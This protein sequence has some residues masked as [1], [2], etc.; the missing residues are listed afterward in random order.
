VAEPEEER[1]TS[2]VKLAVGYAVARILADSPTLAAATP[3][4]LEQIGEA[5]GWE[6]GALWE[7]E[8][9]TEMLRCVDTWQAAGLD[10]HGF[11]ERSKT[12]SFTPG[13]GL[14][15]RVWAAGEPAWI[16]D[17]TQDE[18]FPLASAAAEAG[19]HGAL[20]FPV[21]GATGILGVME[22]FSREVKAP[23]ERLLEAMAAAGNQIG[24]FLQSRLGAE[25]IRRS[26][27]LKTAMLASA[28]DCVIAIDHEGRIIEFN[29]A[30]ER[31]FGYK[32]EDVIGEEMAEL[33]IPPHLRERHRHGLARYLAGG[34][35]PVLDKPVE[36]PAMRSDG[37][38]F[39]AEL[40]ITRIGTDD[41]PMFSGYV[42][43]IT[44][45]K[46]HQQAREF[47]MRA[48]AA[49]DE[50]LDLDAM[51]QTIARLT[52]PYLADACMVDLLE[53]DGSIRRAAS[54][55]GDPSFEPVLEDLRRHRIDPHGAHPVAKAIRTG[56]IELVP[57]ISDSFFWA[58]AG[59][60][61]H[62]NALSRLPAQAALV[63]PLK[64][65]GNM[66]GA[67]LL[68]SFSSER[69]YGPHEMIVIEELSS[70]AAS[71]IENARLFEERSQ[72][73][74]TL[75]QSLL[76]P[77]LPELPGAEV[78]ARFQPAAT[79]GDVGGDFYDV[80]EGRE[81]GWVITIGDV[82]GRGVEAAATTALAR[83]TIR[84]A[85]IQATTP[86][87]I[88]SV[89]NEAL[90][91]QPQELRLCTAAVG[92]LQIEDSRARLSLASGGHPLPLHLRPDGRVEPIGR[93]GTLLGA[94]PN[95]ELGQQ[96]LELSAGDILVFY[97]DGVSELRIGGGQF[98]V[99][100]LTAVVAGCIDL[101]ATATV[102]CI[103]QAVTDARERE[104]HDDAAI[105]VLRILEQEAEPH[106]PPELALSET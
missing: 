91:S 28:L 90:R 38:L 62:Y 63:A 83:H 76:P 51:L 22:F 88:L 31:A 49:L 14:P 18:N 98:G 20:A 27:A 54:A 70:R 80:F 43:D 59:S 66:L 7:V 68:G 29:P 13:V 84:A 53:R 86:A 1:G 81:S 77:R 3:K 21:R 48:S 44:E 73:A 42:R 36:L 4:L 33:I 74:N 30:A 60:E 97:T 78:A 56:Q 72:L 100:E 16:A 5:L 41:P 12:I 93:S 10:A 87:Q 89:L 99:E 55:A 103:N 52:I 94:V 23:D 67:I 24:R 6:T 92:L 45:R 19:L 2:D 15:G 47:L 82:S 58:I 96:E 79:N 101:D 85:A 34:E 95:P 61:E 32:R 37:S 11:E 104:P 71:A 39:E 17:V 35:A 50:S 65:R 75:Q 9:G 40:A 57:D 25:E 64:F 105:L 69:T 46:R 8:P 106:P 26:A 102:E